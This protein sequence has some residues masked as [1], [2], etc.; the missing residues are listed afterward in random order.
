MII[1]QK[2]A[3]SSIQQRN[4]RQGADTSTRNRIVQGRNHLIPGNPDRA[5]VQTW[6]TEDIE[7]QAAGLLVI[8]EMTKDRS[9]VKWLALGVQDTVSFAD[10]RG[11]ETKDHQTLPNLGLGKGGPQVGQQQDQLTEYRLWQ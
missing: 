6:H 5:L 4:A 7:P 2:S 11:V 3:L 9:T 8:L 10:A 1:W